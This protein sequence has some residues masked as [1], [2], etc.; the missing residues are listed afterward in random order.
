MSRIPSQINVDVANL[1][2]AANQLKDGAKTAVAKAIGDAEL[3]SEGPLYKIHDYDE[4]VSPGLTRGSRLEPGEMAKLKAAGYKGFVDLRAEAP[5][6]DLSQSNE[7]RF[8]KDLSQAGSSAAAGVVRGFLTEHGLY[9]PAVSDVAEA[10]QVGAV[11]ALSVPIVDMSSG[12]KDQMLEFLDFATKKENRPAY[13]HCEAGQG[14]TGVAVAVYRMAVQGW[15]ADEAVGEYYAHTAGLKEQEQFIREFGAELKDG[16]LLSRGYPINPPE[17][18]VHP[19]AAPAVAPA[20]TSWLKQVTGAVKLAK[21]GMDPT[22]A[23]ADSAQLSG[24][25]KP[26]TFFQKVEADAAGIENM[27]DGLSQDYDQETKRIHA[28]FYGKTSP[29]QI[30]KVAE[31]MSDEKLKSMSA[32]QRANLA[33]FLTDPDTFN[34]IPT[35][36]ADRGALTAQFVR[37][38]EAGL[39]NP[40]ASPLSAEDQGAVDAVI[41]RMR[42]S[43]NA[44][45][46][47]VSGPAK[48]DFERLTRSTVSRGDWAGFQSYVDKATLTK[49][50][51][52]TLIEPLINGGLIP[53]TGRPGIPTLFVPPGTKVKVEDPNGAFP[54]IFNAID[55]A[56][57]G[58]PVFVSEF[59]VQSD[60]TGQQMAQHLIAAKQRGC[61]VRVMFDPKGSAESNG[62][63]TD[64][65]IYDY[66]RSSGVPTMPF[67]SGTADDHLSHRKIIIAGQTGFI[68]GM[69]IG[70]EYSSIWHDCHSKVTGPGVGDLMQLYTTQWNGALGT[71]LH[72]QDVVTRS[73]WLTSMGNPT[74]FP[75]GFA[76]TFSQQLK[77]VSGAPTGAESTRIVGHIG[78]HDQNMKLTY[79][80]AIATAKDRIYVKSPYTS[81]PDV[82]KALIAAKQSGVPKVVLMVP[83]NNDVKEE[84]DAIRGWYS[85]LLKAGVEVY[86]YKGRSMDHGKDAVFDNVSTIGSSNLDA[87]SLQN[88]DEANEWSSDKAGADKLET[89]LFQ[90][91]MQPSE[92]NRITPETVAGY[93]E[94]DKVR[95]ELA[96][97]AAFDQ[98]I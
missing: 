71:Q 68:G 6:S 14:R 25:G 86:E 47:R 91:D 20:A 42:W 43:K 90:K 32:T 18:S 11:N 38:L 56:K 83:A 39:Q 88:N 80:R 1:K 78:E 70:D 26:L 82:F 51:P 48:A 50:T 23:S 24:Q 64:Q 8:Q 63:P 15:S 72:R 85:D 95:Y 59:A 10:K 79:L 62:R 67:P 44:I 21:D 76:S 30:V 19:S 5:G 96:R 35:F 46:G 34:A 37:V 65:K 69:N 66:L 33:N 52:G 36:S 54:Q 92:S 3:V 28:F 61:D 84:Q 81:D 41:S 9:T 16:K 4:I 2:Q 13:V 57:A 75:N 60:D 55:S 49:Q 73:S 98:L 87:R 27:V 22:R 58:E 77:P 31:G 89:Q 74:L 29:A 94:A 17:A 93:P 40:K 97:N 53:V 12:T 7:T 45:A